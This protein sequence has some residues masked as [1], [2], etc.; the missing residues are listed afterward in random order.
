MRKD[1]RKMLAWL[2]SVGLVTTSSGIVAL[3][4]DGVTITTKKKTVVEKVWE[5]ED[6]HYLTTDMVSE[7][8]T[9]T[10]EGEWK[11]LVVPKELGA[12]Q[13]DLKNTSVKELVIESGVNCDVIIK[14]STI[15]NVVVQEPQIEKIGY[16]EIVAMLASG[17][18]ATEVAQLYRNY[19]IE[20]KAVEAQYPTIVTDEETKINTIKVSGSVGLDL[21]KDN[22]ANISVETTSNS[23]KMK[24]E[25]NNYTGGLSV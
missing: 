16:E 13:I 8:G 18:S 9:A 5:E 12:K 21:S 14:N 20:K 15:G 22:V 6:T 23:E 19:Q 3:A 11:R 25:I 24:V 7:K 10:V 2:I 4:N 17:K 1:A